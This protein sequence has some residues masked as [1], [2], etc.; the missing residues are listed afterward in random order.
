MLIP[1]GQLKSRRKTP[2]PVDAPRK[3]I[4]HSVVERTYN[5][6]QDIF[7][8]YF[9]VT[10]FRSLLGSF[11]TSKNRSSQNLCYYE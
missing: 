3:D 10:D 6:N 11:Y 4:E 9:E 2:R 1:I 7:R 8:Q 5:I